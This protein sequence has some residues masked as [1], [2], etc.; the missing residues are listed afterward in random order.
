MNFNCTLFFFSYETF[1]WLEPNDFIIWPKMFTF[2]KKLSKREQCTFE[3]ISSHLVEVLNLRGRCD[4]IVVG[5]AGT[6]TWAS[7]SC[8]Q[9]FGFA[10]HHWNPRGRPTSY[11]LNWRSGESIRN[12][13]CFFPSSLCSLLLNLLH[14]SP[15][16][17]RG[18]LTYAVVLNLVLLVWLLPTLSRAGWVRRS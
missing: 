2:I 15:L 7:I 11:T 8:H 13:F 1:S 18:I 3:E 12:S 17:F 14:V 5:E 4:G 16:Q 9:E 10:L 6:A